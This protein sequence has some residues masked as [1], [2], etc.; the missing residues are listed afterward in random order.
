M[1][2]NEKQYKKAKADLTKWL[3]AREIFQQGTLN[4]SAKWLLDV[5]RSDIEQQIQS[6]YSDIREYEDTVSRRVHLPPLSVA[7][8]QL[9]VLLI[10][11]RIARHWTQRELA[12]RVGMH[13][14]QIQKYEAENYACA[15]LQTITKIATVLETA[16]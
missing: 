11:W 2:K 6:L 16:H 10:S 9:P 12:E 15:A 14:N 3:E 1:L 5:D 4:A 7:T 13:E 8:A